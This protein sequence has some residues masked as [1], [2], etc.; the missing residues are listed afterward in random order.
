MKSVNASTCPSFVCVNCT[1]YSTFQ[2]T[3]H[4]AGADR[5]TSKRST[6]SAYAKVKSCSATVRLQT[7]VD[8]PTLSLIAKLLFCSFGKVQR[9]C[10]NNEQGD[11]VKDIHCNNKSNTF[12]PLM[13]ITAADITKVSDSESA[14]RFEVL[15]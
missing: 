8:T 6:G 14:Y 15:Y 11:K 5:L 2:H 10:G 7:T 3:Q 1:H 12:N 13:L 4:N 9:G